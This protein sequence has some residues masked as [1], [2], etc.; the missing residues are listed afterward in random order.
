MHSDVIAEELYVGDADAAVEELPDVQL[1]AQARGTHERVALLVMKQHIIQHDA[2]QES[3][4]CVAD[5]DL[6]LQLLRQH[7]RSLRG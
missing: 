7:H 5:A 3:N 2:V 4:A 1:A 6:C